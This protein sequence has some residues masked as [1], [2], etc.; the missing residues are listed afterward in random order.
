MEPIEPLSNNPA[1]PFP[2]GHAF[3]QH[4]TGCPCA[5]REPPVIVGVLCRNEKAFVTHM[6]V[7]LPVVCGSVRARAYIAPKKQIPHSHKTCE[8]GT[9]KTTS[10]YFPVLI[11]EPVR[12]NKKL[13]ILS[14]RIFWM[15]T[16]L[17]TPSRALPHCIKDEPMPFR[18]AL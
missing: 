4:C 11:H 1:G 15:K 10:I 9:P 16:L 12:E 5:K 17:L 8:A 13:G 3:A 14:I 2:H 18:S 6:P 7:C